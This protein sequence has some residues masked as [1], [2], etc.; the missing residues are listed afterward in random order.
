MQSFFLNIKF[1]IPSVNM[2]GLDLES[3]DADVSN[4]IVGI[5]TEEH[6]AELNHKMLNEQG[7]PHDESSLRDIDI[8]VRR[9][10]QSS[11]NLLILPAQISHRL[12]ILLAYLSYRVYLQT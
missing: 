7:D 9:I 10:R 12:P 1:N 8:L 2:G 11:D 6:L 3:I 4:L 5:N